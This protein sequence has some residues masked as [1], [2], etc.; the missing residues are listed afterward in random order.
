MEINGKDFINPT[1]I[2]KSIVKDESIVNKLTPEKLYLSHGD[3]HCNNILC[4][5]SAGQFIFLDCRGK[6]PSGSLYFDPAYDL[7]KLYHDLHSYYSLI[8]KKLFIIH[9]NWENKKPVFEYFFTDQTLTERYNRNY[10][11]VRGIVEKEYKNF[12]NLHYRTDFTEAMLYLTMLP[13]HIRDK[14]EGPVCYVTGVVR[15]NQW[16][17]RNHPELYKALMEE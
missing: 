14:D 16:F 3:L 15:I 4:G 6:S 9:Q 1:R 11:Y 17:N 2:L 13:M 5:L 12:D 10:F 8:E 7:A